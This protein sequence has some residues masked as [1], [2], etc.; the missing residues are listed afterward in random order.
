MRSPHTHL[1]PEDSCTRI[2][3][4]A[5]GGDTGPARQHPD[6]CQSFEGGY[7]PRLVVNSAAITGTEIIYTLDGTEPV[8]GGT[9]YASPIP[10]SVGTIVRA[11]AFAPGAK[12]GAIAMAEYPDAAWAQAPV[13]REITNPDP[14]EALVELSVEPLPEY[15]AITGLTNG[16]A[17]YVGLR[18]VAP[19]G[20]VGYRSEIIG[21][22]AETTPQRSNKFTWPPAAAEA[23]IPPGS[24]PPSR[25]Q[26]ET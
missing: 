23:R 7:P 22:P 13:V 10:L 3:R 15:Y 19:A 24:L 18:S 2:R 4:I 17:H 6:R 25:F 26:E 12:P 11:R 9:V 5:A 16:V 20:D 21:D 14:A 1:A 8:A